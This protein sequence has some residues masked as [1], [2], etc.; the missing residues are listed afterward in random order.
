MDLYEDLTKLAYAGLFRGAAAVGG[1]ALQVGR[2]ALAPSAAT[3][4]GGGVLRSGL[5]TAY[6]FGK[7]MFFFDANP[8]ASLGGKVANGA[9]K[10]FAFGGPMLANAGLKDNASAQ[11]SVGPWTIG[12]PKTA[13]LALEE[14]LCKRAMEVTDALDATAYA[15]FLA[16]KFV[17]ENHWAH[18][19]LD[20]A[21]LTLLGG[22][23]A[24]DLARGRHRK[25]AVKD[26]LGL[27]L[28]GSALHDRHHT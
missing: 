25:A 23:T 7:G 24:Y 26:L 5:S 10:A 14:R 6:N 1:R 21:G 13:A 18:T 9:G 11:A 15:A 19:G 8:N 17:P 22:T 4:K 28:M 3:A 2:Q 16:S 12:G 20:A 27:A